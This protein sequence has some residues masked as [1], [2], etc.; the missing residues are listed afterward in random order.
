MSLVSFPL[1]HKL[2]TTSQDPILEHTKNAIAKQESLR[3]DP[4]LCFGHLAAELHSANREIFP[5]FSK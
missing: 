5:F 4:Q 3:L 2:L 1:V